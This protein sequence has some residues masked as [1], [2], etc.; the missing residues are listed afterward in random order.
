MQTT[1]FVNTAVLSEHI[2][3]W[4]MHVYL[5]SH[6]GRATDV[7]MQSTCQSQ[8]E[9]VLKVPIHHMLSYRSSHGWMREIY[10]VCMLHCLASV[11]WGSYSN[12]CWFCMSR[13]R[14]H[15]I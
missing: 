14:Q 6:T 3:S 1:E 2:V 5:L 15:A 9:R 4:P 7:T 13:C 12:G 10:T 11:L 8:D